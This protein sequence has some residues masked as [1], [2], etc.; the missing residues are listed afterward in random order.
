MEPQRKVVV[1]FVW[2]SNSGP[3]ILMTGIAL[4]SMQI[5]II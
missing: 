4:P 5:T 1:Y 3:G 2:E